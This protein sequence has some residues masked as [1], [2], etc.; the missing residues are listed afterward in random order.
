M[1]D[2]RTVLFLGCND[3]QVPYLRTILGR[4]CRVVGVD[5]NPDAPGASLCH[6]FVAAG[7][8]QDDRLRAVVEEED[9]GREDVVFTAA[10]HFACQGAASAAKAAGI[11]WPSREIID[12]CMDK[13]RFYRFLVAQ[14]APVP[15]FQVVTSAAELSS[16]FE[17]W[18]TG[19]AA[20]LKSDCSKNPNYIF[21]IPPGERSDLA[22]PWTRDRYLD[23][24]YVLQ[25]EFQGQGVRLNL[26]PGG[27]AIYP[28]DKSEGLSNAAA[29]A[30]L[31]RTGAQAGLE[32]VVEALE[33]QDRL[34]K[35]DVLVN[36]ADWVVIDIGLDPPARMLADYEARSLDFYRFYV[37]LYLGPENKGTV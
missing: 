36:G 29:Q 10:A 7:Y 31:D 25:E 15:R 2:Q 1:G 27:R 23:H 6:R 5:R 32:K 19:M 35:F 4:G 24:G 34:V 8:D 9:M 26:F 3:D 22:V 21:R 33:L 30:S 16:A 13:I 28:F 12:L 17:T 18:P 20:W 11:D 37:D 14:D